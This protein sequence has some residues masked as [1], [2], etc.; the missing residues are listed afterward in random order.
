MRK[1][2]HPCGNF[3]VQQFLHLEI[4]PFNHIADGQ[5][6]LFQLP[7]QVNQIHFKIHNTVIWVLYFMHL[8]LLCTGYLSTQETG[9]FASFS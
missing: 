6:L 8:F 9:Y 4:F 3:A 1:Q 2:V 7:E 5:I